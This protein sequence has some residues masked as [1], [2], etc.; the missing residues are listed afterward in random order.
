[1]TSQAVNEIRSLLLGEEPYRRP[2]TPEPD[3]I[4]EI[5]P[6]MPPYLINRLL[7][8]RYFLISD[9]KQRAPLFVALLKKLPKPERK[10]FLRS[11]LSR[12][13]EMAD[14]VPSAFLNEAIEAAGIIEWKPTRLAVLTRLSPR[15]ANVQ[16]RNKMIEDAITATREIPDSFFR[17]EVLST[18]V[19]KLPQ[20]ERKKLIEEA[21][22]TARAIDTDEERAEALAAVGAHLSEP[23]KSKVLK[24]AL[25]ASET[26]FP[27]AFLTSDSLNVLTELAPQLSERQLQAAIE[28]AE[29]YEYGYDRVKVLAALTPHLSEPTKINLL[30][31]VL[32]VAEAIPSEQEKAQALTDLAPR[33]PEEMVPR[34]LTIAQNIHDNWWRARALSSL[35]PLLPTERQERIAKEVTAI[36]GERLRLLL[37]QLPEQQRLGLLEEAVERFVQNHAPKLKGERREA[38][39]PV[40]PPEERIVNTGFS[41]QTDAAQPLDKAVPLAPAQVYYFWFEVGPPMPGSIEVKPEPLMVEF[42]PSEAR[43]KVALFAFEGE[44]EIIR[45]RDV[46]E[47]Q[48]MKDGTVQVARQAELP[49]DISPNSDLLRKRLFFPIRTPNKEGEFRLRC[50]I[51][52]E[53]IL[54]ESRLIQVHISRSQARSEA[55]MLRSTLEYSMSKALNPNYLVRMNPQTL[56]LMLND[57]GDGTHCF[58]LFGVEDYKSDTCFDV[59]TLE[60]LIESARGALRQ[61]SWGDEDPWSS[62]KPYRYEETLNQKRLRDDLVQFAIR[63]YRFWLRLTQKI[64]GGR[65][66]VDR[67]VD[68][69]SKPTVLEFAIKDKTEASD[70][71]FPAAMIYD[72]LLDTNL[73][74]E[75]Y[76]LCPSFLEA[77]E[78][79]EPLEEASCFKGNCPSRGNLAVVCP[80]GFW[81]FRHSIGVPLGSAS[82]TN[83][84]VLYKDAPEVTVAPFLSFSK[85]PEHENNLKALKMVWNFAKSREDTF[86]KL[87]PPTRPHLVYFY[88]HGGLAGGNPYIRVGTKDERGITPDNFYAMGVPAMSP[89]PL[90]FI[91]GCHTTALEP[92]QMLDF[93]TTFVVTHRA[94]GV[95][96][97]EITVFEPLA[98]AFAEECLR[99]FLVNG[100]TIGDA[101]RA[102][103]LKLLKQGNPLGL[104][105][106]IYANATLRLRKAG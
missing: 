105:Y 26:S 79:Q 38:P 4:A 45:G 36:S 54:V 22:Q 70:H 102:T 96:G 93:V 23:L 97:T 72:Y 81:G 46:G 63:G 67:L 25:L 11:L 48:V 69:M 82:E 35:Y 8:L 73:N 34:A 94:A 31:K 56:S 9:E 19:S 3:I 101:V 88:C 37:S 40:R 76:K 47:I 29:S 91:N 2:R 43:L 17:L 15:L 95:I 65:P 106:T 92:K 42:L 32:S 33:L 14:D 30:N 60:G 89:Q 52:Y 27:D 61:A 68:L 1:M 64:A 103:R 51:Y 85:W 80:S 10:V 6:I 71:M 87:K 78:K 58:R 83:H 7:G 75:D 24:E 100:E 98:C 66:D 86:T 21:L 90:V 104:V 99:R 55:P 18:L 62:D 28:A 59:R 77:L 39:S 53:Q 74:L 16:K 13:P 20:R 50:N 84:E 44:I 57:N 12:Y 49:K 5:I 41:S